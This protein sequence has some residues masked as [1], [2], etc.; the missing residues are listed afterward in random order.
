M[1]WW[2]L[3]TGV[4]GGEWEK[5][6]HVRSSLWRSRKCFVTRQKC[7]L[8]N[9]ANALNAT[10]SCSLKWLILQCVNFISLQIMFIKLKIR[11]LSSTS[12]R[13]SAQ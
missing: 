11:S 10:E 4:G 12:H 2:F 13:S 1:A 3:G 6:P 8:H 9:T 7:W 5:L